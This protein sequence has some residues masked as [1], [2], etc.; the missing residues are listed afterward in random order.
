M[1]TKSISS[2]DKYVAFELHFR[3]N[4]ARV[5]KGDE[6]KKGDSDTA[7]GAD[8]KPAVGGDATAIGAQL[9]RIRDVVDDVASESSSN[10]RVM[11]LTILET[12]CLLVVTTIE[13]YLIRSWFASHSPKAREWA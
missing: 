12:A 2:A 9:S 1:G 8:E 5:Q 3:D 13:I 10:A 7:L 11:W 6:I 4:G